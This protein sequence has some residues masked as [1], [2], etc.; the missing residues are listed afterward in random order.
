MTPQ[1]L[2]K[3]AVLLACFRLQAEIEMLL[4][5]H[6]TG[7]RYGKSANVDLN[8]LGWFNPKAGAEIVTLEREYR[9]L[10]Q[11]TCFP[12]RSPRQVLVS[13]HIEDIF[14][15]ALAEARIK[16]QYVLDSAIIPVEFTNPG[17]LHRQHA[18][19]AM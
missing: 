6:P 11:S 9:D 2:H 12:G 16:L 14:E 4:V 7:V 10:P 18:T 3:K 8:L 17:C 15:K 19:E 1:N 5:A 13:L